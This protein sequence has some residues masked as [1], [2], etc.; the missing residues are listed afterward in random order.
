DLYNELT[1]ASA[2]LS[3]SGDEVSADLVYGGDVAKGKKFANSLLL[4]L[5]MRYSKLNPA[6]AE[7]IVSEAFN[8]GVMETNDDDAYIVYTEVYAHPMNGIATNNPRFYHLA[9]PLID[10]L[11]ATNDPRSPFIA[12]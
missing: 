10:E 9:E 2:A 11:K 7:A 3:S 1:S 12:A 6:R 5:G 4:R 8:A